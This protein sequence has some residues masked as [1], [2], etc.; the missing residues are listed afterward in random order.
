M[1]TSVDSCSQKSI[2][3]R[4]LGIIIGTRGVCSG[5][6]LLAVQRN[7]SPHCSTE[8][9]DETPD[10]CLVGYPEN[11]RKVK[12][13]F[14]VLPCLDSRM[15]PQEFYKLYVENQELYEVKLVLSLKKCHI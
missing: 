3:Q 6:V 11:K 12:I 8:A 7:I 4:C 5:Q 9:G 13:G 14:Y 2:N 15:S 10:F 1:S